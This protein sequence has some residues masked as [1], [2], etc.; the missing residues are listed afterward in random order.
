MSGVGT[1]L[2]V[3][4]GGFLGSHVCRAF[5]GDINLI[6]T[7]SNTNLLPRPGWIHLDMVDPDTLRNL[8][9][10]LDAIIY[11]AQSPYYKDFP[12]HSN[13]IWE[14]NVQGVHRLLEYARQAGVQHFVLASS[15][16]V[17][18]PSDADLRETD[19]L[20]LAPGGSFYARSKIAAE[21]LMNAYADFFS[22]TILRFFTMY[23]PRLAPD[24]LLARM[25]RSVLHGLPVSLSGKD[26]FAFNPVHADDAARAVVRAVLLEE[27]HTINVAGPEVVTLG[28]VCR[29]MSRVMGRE[30]VCSQQGDD[31]R[32]VADISAMKRNLT[33]PRI[34]VES[35]LTAFARDLLEGSSSKSQT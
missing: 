35:G 30:P 4:A 19:P 33:V 8:P 34:G 28:Q 29:I 32:M 12:G 27:N 18:L 26:G 22:T 31:W 9:P 25:A 23:G 11:L 1:C 15:G 16:S 14:V 21:L 24:M 2:V 3:G 5:P 10:R 6:Q 17:Y 13:H 20:W 7:T